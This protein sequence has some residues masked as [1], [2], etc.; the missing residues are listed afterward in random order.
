LSLCA[1]AYGDRAGRDTVCF[2]MATNA[3]FIKRIYPKAEM[4]QVASFLSGCGAARSAELTIHRHE[5]NDGPASSQL[6]QA[7]PVLASLDRASENSA[8]EA[9]H[10]VDVDNAQHKMI[11][12][13]NADHCLR[14]PGD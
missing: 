9:K 3:R 7:D 6:N 5:I 11:D 8:V 2:E 14:D 10:A 1:V 4:I 13:A 12:F